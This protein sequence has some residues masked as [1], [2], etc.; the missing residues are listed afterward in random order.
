M[1]YTPLLEKSV[2]MSPLVCVCEKKKCAICLLCVYGNTI[3]KKLNVLETSKC[4]EFNTSNT[5]CK[6]KT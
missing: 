3:S 5:L 2:S 4:L 6:G 1:A